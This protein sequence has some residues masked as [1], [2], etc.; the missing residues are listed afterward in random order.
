MVDTHYGAVDVKYL[1]SLEDFYADVFDFNALEGVDEEFQP[2][3]SADIPP[4]LVDFVDFGDD[5]LIL[6]EAGT[7]L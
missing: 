3:C 6:D 4:P 5:E 7:T 1:I 2:S